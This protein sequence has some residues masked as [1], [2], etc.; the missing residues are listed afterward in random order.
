MPSHQVTTPLRPH[1]AQRPA[2]HRVDLSITPPLRRT[3]PK[4]KRPT[5]TDMQLRGTATHEP[6]ELHSLHSRSGPLCAPAGFATCYGPHPRSP[7]I[8]GFRHW[9]P[10]RP[11]VTPL[12][13]CWTHPKSD[14][15]GNVCGQSDSSPAHPPTTRCTSSAQPRRRPEG[16]SQV[17]GGHPGASRSRSSKTRSRFRPTVVRRA[18]SAST[19][20]HTLF[21]Q[22]RRHPA[23][24]P[25]TE[26]S[27]SH[28][29]RDGS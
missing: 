12:V 6:P 24:H 7:L 11:V 19:S 28:L 25:T 16:R 10:V 22:T 29:P 3:I 2:G 21:E 18:F 8:Q 9:S 17:P 14:T 1:T 23:P 27:G 15:T 13:S 20:G 5:M 4:R 26:L